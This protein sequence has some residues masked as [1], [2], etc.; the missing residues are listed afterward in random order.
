MWAIAGILVQ[1]FTAN[2][3]N[4][5]YEIPVTIVVV[6]I[7]MIITWCIGERAKEYGYSYINNSFNTYEELENTEQDT[8]ETV[9]SSTET[10]IM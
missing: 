8:K 2:I 9:D 10:V 7:A 4:L 5:K 1:T 3:K 6:L